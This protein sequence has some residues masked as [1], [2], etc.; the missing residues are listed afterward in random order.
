MPSAASSVTRWCIRRSGGRH[1]GFCVPR[2]D[3]PG[4]R[5]SRRRSRVATAHIEFFLAR[6]VVERLVIDR[7]GH[8]GDGARLCRRTDAHVPTHHSAARPSRWPPY[9]AIIPIGGVLQVERTCSGSRHSAAISVSAAVAQSST[10]RP[11]ATAPGTQYRGGDPAQAELDCA[12]APLIDAHGLGRRRLMLHA[13]TAGTHDVLKVGFIAAHSHD[14]VPVDR[15]PILDPHLGGALDAGWAIAE[16]LIAIG[17]PLDIQ[18]T[19][20]DNGLDVDVRGSGP[21][22]AAMIAKLSVIAEQH[23]LMRHG[24]WRLTAT[25]AQDWIGASRPAAGLVPAG[26]RRRRRDAGCARE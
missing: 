11:N 7:V 12:V 23:R 10:G 9:R 6:A 21:L 19:A 26:N 3:A 17:K 4:S 2:W 5:Y 13:R 25:C 18:I 20:T 14:I 1:R 15:C 22:P 16:P 24:E 8:L